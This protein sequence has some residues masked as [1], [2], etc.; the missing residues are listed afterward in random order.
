MA[1]APAPAR[2]G[3]GGLL[4]DWRRLRGMSQLELALEAGV[5]TRHLSFL[6]TG[7]AR[8]SRQMV[9]QLAERLQVPSPD[10]N[11]LLLA[12][13][14][15]PIHDER[16]PDDPHMEPI[17][18]ALRV[19]LEGHDPNPAI[20]VDRGW[21]LVA[22][23]RAATLLL[24]GLPDELLA[25]PMNF[26]RATLHPDGLAPSIANLRQWKEQVLG[27]LAREAILTGNPALRTLYQELDAYPAPAGGPDQPLPYGDVAL[28]LCL[29]TP[30]G[31][32]RLLSTVTTFGTPA[33]T[34]VEDYF[35]Q[36][37]LAADR[38]SAD[39]LRRRAAVT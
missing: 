37:F 12:A 29:R 35:I 6:E 15:A 21:E 26:L 28:P 25:P 3:V 34:T 5:S 24:D 4:R 38:F 19:V 13:G 39:T 31:E 20:V 2:T 10:R 30:H 14:Y 11:R 23:N 32:L 22:H 1:T 27:R 7:R 33:D 8:P 17:R 18:A 16:S 9:L 36:S